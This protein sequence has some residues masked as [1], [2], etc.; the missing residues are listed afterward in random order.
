MN[1]KYYAA[2]HKDSD[3]LKN[4]SSGGMFTAIADYI[5]SKNGIIFGA[6]FD[7]TEYTVKHISVTSKDELQKLRKSKYVYSDLKECI[8]EIKKAVE[9]E[10][11][12]LFT[13]TPCQVAAIKNMYGHYDKLFIVDLFCHGTLEPKL[14]KQYLES[15][16]KKITGIDFR[17]QSLNKKSNFRFQLYSDKE[18]FLDGEYGNDI[19]TY[20]FI[21]SAGL[22]DVCFKCSYAAKKHLSDITIG[23]WD[24]E[25]PYEWNLIYNKLHPSILSVNTKRGK[26]IFENIKNEINYIS[27]DEKEKDVLFYYRQHEKLRGIWGYE[28]D[29]KKEFVDLYNRYGFIYAANYLMFKDEIKLI[30]KVLRK[31]N[32]KCVLYGC[33]V[34]GK[35]IYEI[36]NNVYKNELEVDF[37]VVS[38]KTKNPEKIENK[39]IYELNEI[40]DRL[41]DKTI[42]VSVKNSNVIDEVLN[43]LKK[44]GL[45]NYVTW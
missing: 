44:R 1:G 28:P 40:S 6:A 11:Y 8:F 31:G 38:D 45:D 42:I 30:E 5:I 15:F 24:F 17:G 34:S 27:I 33:G 26:E 32:K 29:I 10:K 43:E 23:D 22:R 19:I 9:S 35:K 20:L 21:S 39:R 37:F 36:I 14:F 12:I 4:S 16:D 18:K 3:V 41:N 13:G 7:S 2:C 25:Y